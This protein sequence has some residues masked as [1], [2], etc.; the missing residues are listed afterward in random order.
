MALHKP[1]TQSS[2]Y[3]GTG[4]DQ[5]PQFGNDGILESKPRDPYLM[6]HTNADNPAW[7]QVDLEKVHTL[8]HLK[9]YNR[10]ACCQEKARTIQVLLST[11]GAHWDKVYAHKGTPFDVL[12]VDLG[13]RSA[14]YVKLQLAEPGFLHFQECEIF[15]N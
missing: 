6:V 1:A 4:V 14:R 12:T 10:K 5:G 15:G 9:I 2:I 3:R 11:D 8:N 7:W 13:N